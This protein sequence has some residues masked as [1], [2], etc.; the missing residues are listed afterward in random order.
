MP[1]FGIAVFVIL[2]ICAA[3]ASA[4][5]TTN[6]SGGTTK[7]SAQPAS[8]DCAGFVGYSAQLSD[9]SGAS[10]VGR[11]DFDFAY[12]YSAVG[13][14]ASAGQA[15]P[16][17]ATGEVNNSAVCAVYASHTD[18]AISGTLDEKRWGSSTSTVSKGATL[19]YLWQVQITTLCVT[20][21]T[22]V[23]KDDED[24]SQGHG[25]LI[26]GSGVHAS[27]MPEPGEGALIGRLSGA[28]EVGR[29][30]TYIARNRTKVAWNGTN[31]K[32][33]SAYSF[34]GTYYIV[35]RFHGVVVNAGF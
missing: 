5:S 35:P 33:D 8:P 28:V 11:D 14:G 19:D 22:T 21:G 10:G 7:R 32:V 13:S 2:L 12:Q 16:S 4:S 9:D 15:A 30:H 31:P 17:A 3:G 6:A 23:V 20:I 34:D 26:Q 25:T 27:N 1:R 24:Q 29:A 18:G